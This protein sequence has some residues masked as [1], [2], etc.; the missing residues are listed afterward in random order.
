MLNELTYIERNLR[1]CLFNSTSCP[2]DTDRSYWIKQLLFW[3]LELENCPDL[4]KRDDAHTKY[5]NKLKITSEIV[6]TR[7]GIIFN[8]IVYIRGVLHS[9]FTRGSFECQVYCEDVEVIWRILQTNVSPEE[10]KNEVKHILDI[11]SI[12]QEFYPS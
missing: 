3:Q 7:L 11:Y 12:N 9:E 5:K 8:G 10:K 1:D 2:V 4:I 6:A